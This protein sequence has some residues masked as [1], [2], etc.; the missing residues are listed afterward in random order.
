[1][2]LDHREFQSFVHYPRIGRTGGHPP[3]HAVGSVRHDS[4]QPQRHPYARRYLIPTLTRKTTRIMISKVL[5]F[6][7]SSVSVPA[8]SSVVV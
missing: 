6:D 5:E 1:L 7:Y 8:P 2:A 4:F 3:L